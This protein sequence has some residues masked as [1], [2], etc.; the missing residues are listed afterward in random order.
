MN[1]AEGFKKRQSREYE[2]FKVKISTKRDK[3]INTRNR[4]Y[5]R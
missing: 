5:D 4:E 1:N 2:M 3:L